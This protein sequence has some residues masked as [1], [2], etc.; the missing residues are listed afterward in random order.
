MA[1]KQKSAEAE[2][3]S[4]EHQVGNV[5]RLVNLIVAVL[6]TS[7]AYIL[8]ATDPDWW[9]WAPVYAVGSLISFGLFVRIL[10]ENYIP[11]SNSISDHCIRSFRSSFV[12]YVSD[13]LTS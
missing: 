3:N 7:R 5:W 11:K 8:V 4:L 12:N 6:L 2:S 9:I 10:P 1:R 13:C